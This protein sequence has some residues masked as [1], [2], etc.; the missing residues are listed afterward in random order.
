MDGLLLFVLWRLIYLIL[1]F[2][3]PQNPYGAPLLIRNDDLVW[4]Q[5]GI[6]IVLSVCRKSS[7]PPIYTRVSRYQDWISNVTGSNQTGFVTFSS[8]GEDGVSTSTS[9]P[10]GTSLTPPVVPPGT[11]PTP[12]VVPLRTTCDRSIFSSS[13]KLS[14]TFF[15]SISALLFSLVVLVV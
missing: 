10:P 15:T 2:A 9:S 4:I 11:N 8:S 7:S 12:P 6:A 1:K 3:F 13:E 5:I 14:S